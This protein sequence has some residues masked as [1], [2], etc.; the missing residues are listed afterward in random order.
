MTSDKRK[1]DQRLASANY[2]A[3][4]KAVLEDLIKANALLKAKLKEQ[5]D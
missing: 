2:R 1:E 5:E 4:Q 3:K